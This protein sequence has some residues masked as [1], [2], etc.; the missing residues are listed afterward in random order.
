MTPF[1]LVQ[2]M[3][4][5]AAGDKP[6]SAEATR[7]LWGVFF[8]LVEL[9][10]GN[11]MDEAKE[12]DATALAGEIAARHNHQHQWQGDRSLFRR[13]SAGLTPGTSAFE[14]FEKAHQKA[15]ADLAR[16]PRRGG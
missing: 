10:H 7:R 5:A 11:R 8:L 3:L 6:L 12:R 4:S 15:L 2:I 14:V 13:F 9:E 1:P 16:R